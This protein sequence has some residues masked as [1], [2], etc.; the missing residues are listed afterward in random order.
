MWNNLNKYFEAIKFQKKLLRLTISE[1]MCYF[2]KKFQIESHQMTV[3][4]IY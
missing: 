3:G 4:L 2:L 1:K